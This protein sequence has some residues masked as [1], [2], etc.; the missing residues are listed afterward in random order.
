MS[1]WNS[2]SGENIAHADTMWSAGAE[3]WAAYQEKQFAPLFAEGLERVGVGPGVA[4]LDAGCGAGLACALA[5]ARG[6]RVWGLDAATGMIAIA[7]RRAPE[8]HFTLGDMERMPY[9]DA[10][11]D[12]VTG[13]NSFTYTSHPVQALR[14]ARRVV[15]AGGVV[16]ATSWGRREAS[17]AAAYMTA[18]ARLLPLPPPGSASPFAYSAPGVFEA[19]AAEA[20]LTPVSVEPVPCPWEYPDLE[21]LLCGILS[22]GNYVRARALVGEQALRDA[23][24]DA[25]APFARADGSYRLENEFRFLLFRA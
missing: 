2:A 18:I 11:F 12:V 7:S 14:E 4:L 16:L 24:R 5:V 3:N 8:A 22:S 25:V 19:L 20:G 13:F 21:S 23:V 17:Q 9:T 15:R 10:T 6:A 1:E